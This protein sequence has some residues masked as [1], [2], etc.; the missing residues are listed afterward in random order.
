[1]FVGLFVAASHRTRRRRRDKE[2]EALLF[3]LIP[4]WV[5]PQP[6]MRK[7]VFAGCLL[8]KHVFFSKRFSAT[9]HPLRWSILNERECVVYWY[10]IQ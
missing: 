6:E 10:S 2:E 1:M 9:S 5:F 3:K 4:Y 8:Q 7:R